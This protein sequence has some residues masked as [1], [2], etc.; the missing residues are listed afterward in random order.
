MNDA[1]VESQLKK[2]RPVGPAA[3]LRDRVLTVDSYSRAN[4]L[5]VAAL[6]FVIIALQVLAEAERRSVQARLENPAE[7]ESLIAELAEQLGGDEIAL[8][9]ARALIEMSRAPGAVE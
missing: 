6:V 4:W 3:G 1:D 8:V 2:Y 9:T 7:Q 5:P